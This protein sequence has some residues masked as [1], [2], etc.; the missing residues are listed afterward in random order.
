MQ[1]PDSRGRCLAR[2]ARR[3]HC[4]RVHRDHRA[5]DQG[6]DQQVHDPQKRPAAEA[7]IQTTQLTEA[8]NR[9]CAAKHMQIN[10]HAT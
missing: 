7:D 1:R 9:I 10:G 5:G 3:S 6:E 4:V 2:G 8:D